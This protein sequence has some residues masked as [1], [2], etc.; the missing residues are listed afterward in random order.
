LVR[1]CSSW[2]TILQ[3]STVTTWVGTLTSD[4]P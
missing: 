1:P 2:M 3:T 4:N